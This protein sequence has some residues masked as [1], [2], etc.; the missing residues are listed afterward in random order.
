MYISTSNE[1]IE[2]F[3]DLYYVADELDEKTAS[4]YFNIMYGKKPE[5]VNQQKLVTGFSGL[6]DTKNLEIAIVKMNK[7]GSPKIEF[8]EEGGT[9]TYCY[10][11]KYPFKGLPL[12][13]YVE[14]LVSIK[15]MFME[16][17]RLFRHKAMIPFISL[18]VIIPNRKKVLDLIFD[19]Y[20]NI[21]S[22]SFTN[23][24]LEPKKYCDSVR[25][26]YRTFEVI[27]QTEKTKKVRDI[28]CTLIEYDNAYRYRLQD[29]AQEFDKD[30]F[31]INGKKEL[32]RVL[33]IMILRE[34]NEGMK[35][36]WRLFK[37]YLPFALKIINKDFLNFIKE[38]DLT[39][40]YIDESDRYFMS[41]KS[42]Y[43]YEGVSFEERYKLKQKIDEE[44][45]KETGEK[46]ITT[47][48]Q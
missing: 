28:V 36:K 12:Q 7:N 27:S 42:D 47:P 18:L 3:S 32:D 20:I 33:D 1:T 4:E 30:R 29:A 40:L 16:S 17:L 5:L 19:F 10:G 26:I 22:H 34:K 21:A 23:C 45:Q 41:M 6:D 31:F 11:Y 48:I 15:R 13:K 43:N 2:L 25:E 24:I 8:P 35:D 39:K 9:L 44:Y 46:F 14:I 38:I 37:R